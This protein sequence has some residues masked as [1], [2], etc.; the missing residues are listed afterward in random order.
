MSYYLRVEAVNLGNFIYDTNDLSTIRGGGLLLLDATHEVETIIKKE[1]SNKLTTITKGASWALFE[2]QT[3]KNT[4]IQIRQN[5]L[6]R[7]N[8]EKEGNQLNP[9][10][11][12][13][14]VVDVLEKTNSYTQDRDSLHT[15][16]RW[17]QMQSPSLSIPKIS[18]EVCALD[19]V[20]PACVQ[21]Y[22][23]S[24]QAISLSPSVAARRDYG[25]EQKRGEFYESRTKLPGLKF[26]R[27]LD[28]LS[29]D[30]KQGILNGK[31]AVI[32]IDGNKFGQIARECKDAKERTS[33]D[34]KL[35]KGQNAVLK[36]LLRK[37]NKNS[38]WKNN[39]RIRLETLLWG[40]DEIIWI[41]PAWL[42]WETLN[43]FFKQADEEIK[44]DKKLFERSGYRSSNGKLTHA[45]GLV[46]CHHNAPIHRITALARSLADIPK[47]QDEYKYKNMVAYQILESFDHAGRNIEQ[48]REKRLGDLAQ[49]EHL[50][51]AAEKMEEIEKDIKILK[52]NDF[53]RRK[54]YQ[55]INA[56]LEKDKKQADSLKE[57]LVK[58]SPEIQKTLD[59][60]KV[61]CG[62][63]NAYWLHL[64]DLWDYLASEVSEHV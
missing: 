6:E 60:L 62:G 61:R 7:L 46:F 22:S 63:E 21:D 25:K 9:L 64:T 49:P 4:A 51:I 55:I 3:D 45:A 43:L 34:D 13:T 15:L 56:L 59:N 26:T 41:V 58:D 8:E 19:K 50:L 47:N 53:P 12:A 31:I 11:H 52:D 33:F 23:K 37:T 35:S 17:Q 57:K 36:A 10:R 40:G 1:L 38:S 29:N 20:R 28:E 42:G 48:Y 2:L 5:I 30:P 54:S 27:D 14:F 44:I 39:G 18:D 32:Y 16:N 24:G